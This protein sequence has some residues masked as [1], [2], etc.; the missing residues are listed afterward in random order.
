MTT[1]LPPPAEPRGGAVVLD[2]VSWADY[3]AMLRIVGDR[4]IRV[5]YDRGLMEVRMPLHG[6][7]KKLL[8]RMV[9]T[10]GE[11]LEIPVVAVGAATFSR[12][13]LDRG[14]EPDECYYLASAPRVRNWDR[15]D[16]AFDPPPDQ[17]IEVDITR[18]SINRLGVYSALGVPEVWRFDGEALVFLGRG[19]DGAYAPRQTSVTFPFLAAAELLPFL[20]TDQANDSRWGRTFRE[21]VRA[22]LL[23]SHRPGGAPS[24]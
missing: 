22:V 23:P 11:E 24:G 4:P 8:G 21:W 1:T 17:V 3:E 19:A 14:L 16:L 18:S 2:G 6:R 9:E 13:D 5:T 7:A 15:I 10:I 20:Q 12:Q